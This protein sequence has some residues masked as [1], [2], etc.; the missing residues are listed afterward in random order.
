MPGP[1]FSSP[2]RRPSS[3]M[4]RLGSLPFSDRLRYIVPMR[5]LNAA[6]L[7]LAAL[8]TL[9]PGSRAQSPP[10]AGAFPPVLLITLDTTR[11]DKLGCYGSREGLTPSLDG[12]AKRSTLFER[13]ESSVPQ[14]MPSHVTLFSGLQPYSHGVRKNL[15]VLVPATIPFLPEE[16]SKA[17]YGTAA[18]VSAYVLTGHYGMSRGFDTYDDSFSDPRRRTEVDRPADQTLS[19]ALDWITR[20]EGRWFC[21][22]HL[23]D[24]HIPYAPPEPFASRYSTRPYDGEV[25]FMDEQLGRFFAALGRTGALDRALVVVAGDHGEALGEHGEPTHGIFIYEATT[26]VPL[27]VHLP[28]QTQGRRVAGPV[29]L[30]DVAP[31]LRELLGL[32]RPAEVDGVSFAP[33]LRGEAAPPRSLYLESLEGLYSFGWAPLYGRVQEGWKLILAPR[34]ELYDLPKD[35]GERT[36][37][38][39]VDLERTR[40]MRA[41]LSGELARARTAAS[42]P[43]DLS[44]EEIESL[45]SLGYIAGTPGK[46]GATYADPKD[47]IREMGEHGRA[48]ALMDEKR[49]AEAGPLFESLYKRGNHS[50][51][52]CFNLAICFQDQDPEKALRYAKEAIQLRPDFPQAYHRALTILINRGRYLEAKRVGDLGLKETGATGDYDGVIATLTAWAAHM[53]GSPP[54]EVDAYLDR[55]VRG[56]VENFMGYK[57]RALLALKRGD[58]AS[59]LSQVRKFAAVAPPGE[60]EKLGQDP[61]FQELREEPEFWKLVLSNRGG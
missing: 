47:G 5:R 2:R 6:P 28:G 53:N 23:F 4:A 48:T 31:T 46:K 40:R 55:A 33:A 21:W 56:G 3:R 25:A 42:R 19:L 20:Q 13:C 52:L 38:A 51:S 17:G 57:L 29:G 10:A 27:L 61:G 39:A 60:V 12:F 26:H 44:R 43:I 58:R 32:P 35:P 59:A 37:R 50:A 49:F 7:V 14:T 8:L 45:K 16:M 36:N 34:V 22:V 41:D 1:S 18:F 15:E 11:A 24:P 9:A 54:A 30:V